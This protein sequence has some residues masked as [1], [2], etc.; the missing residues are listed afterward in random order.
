MFQAAGSFTHIVATQHRQ[1]HVLIKHGVY[2]YFRHP[3][4]FGW[5]L[6]ATS[7]QL[8]LFNP[9][10]FIGTIFLAY[11]FFSD[12]IPY[13]EAALIRFFGTEYVQYRDS[14]STWI[15]FIR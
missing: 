7:L 1:E 15:P 10:F 12:R 9:V 5:F 4:Y 2:K 6:W 3:S 14:T 8:L 13:E 11:S